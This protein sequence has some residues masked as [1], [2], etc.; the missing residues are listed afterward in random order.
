MQRVRVSYGV[1]LMT[2]SKKS[3][4]NPPKF[5]SQISKKNPQQILL[6]STEKRGKV[7][8]IFLR[9]LETPKT[10]QL[11]GGFNPFAKYQH[12]S[13]NGSFPQGSG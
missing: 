13:Q 4:W 3:T 5:I 8:P 2:L 1:N 6:I 7:E 10:Q 12:I 9:Q 11:V